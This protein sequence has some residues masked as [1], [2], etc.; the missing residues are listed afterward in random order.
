METRFMVAAARDASALPTSVE[1]VKV[2]LRTTGE[3]SSRSP[4]AAGRP[5]VTRL[6]TPAGSPASASRS[7]TATAHSGVCSAGLSTIVQPA[8]TAG[9]TLRVIIEIG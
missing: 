3:S 5:V 2:S 4:T 7:K 9:A 1:P 8:A 6:A